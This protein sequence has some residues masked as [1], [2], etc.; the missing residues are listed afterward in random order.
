MSSSILIRKA[1]KRKQSFCNSRSAAEN[2]LFREAKRF[3]YS[4]KYC[5]R[6]CILTAVIDDFFGVTKKMRAKKSFFSVLQLVWP[7]LHVVCV[8]LS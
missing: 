4:E 1:D 7:A 3:Y 2:N 8:L 6:A 5:D